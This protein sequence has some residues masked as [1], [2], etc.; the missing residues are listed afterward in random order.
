MPHS[1]KP[2]MADQCGGKLKI[3]KNFIWFENVDKWSSPRV[4]WPVHGA[5]TNMADGGDK[6]VLLSY[7]LEH[8]TA[9]I[10]NAATLRN[11]VNS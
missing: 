8:F 1:S 5:K 10:N 2:S 3:F 7:H 9:I 11:F 4:S 6:N